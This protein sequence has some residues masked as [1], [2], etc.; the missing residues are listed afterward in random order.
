MK[1]KKKRFI[2]EQFQ[3]SGNVEEEHHVV[4]VNFDKTGKLTGFKILEV[5][6]THLPE[7]RFRLILN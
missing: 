4:I 5:P 6:E 7:P 2:E 3:I 1:K